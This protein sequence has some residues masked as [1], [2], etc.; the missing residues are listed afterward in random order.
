[1]FNDKYGL[2]EAV[3][4]G[5]KTQTR[6]ICLHDRPEATYEIAFPV[7]EDNDFDEEGNPTSPLY[8]AFCWINEAGQ[9]TDWN[10]PAYKVGEIVA[11]AQSYKD[12][13]C[14]AL[15]D[16]LKEVY[17]TEPAKLTGWRNKMFV[18][19]DLMSHRIRITNVRVER[20]QDISDADCIA[21]G[22]NEVCVSNN[23][24]N[25]ASHWEYNVP[26][27][28]DFGRAKLLR[29]LTPQETYA[30]LIDRISGNGT[31]QRNPCVFVYD[32]ELVK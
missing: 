13:A 15:F 4:S 6:R 2:T 21:E 9:F 16:D 32:F 8:G 3:L 18:R 7:F 10:I 26:Y 25:S 28:D 19:A 17:R 29:G 27:E 24:G 14:G 1:M 30:A 22:I 12:I 11:I 20:L 31:F 23:W 5:R